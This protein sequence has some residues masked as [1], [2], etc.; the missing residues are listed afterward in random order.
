M[1]FAKDSNVIVDG[2]PVVLADSGVRTANG[3]GSPMAMGERSTLRL[4]LNV[5]AASGGTPTMTASVQHSEDGQSWSN[6]S[7]FTAATGTG[8][9]RKVF[10]GL[11][12]FVRVSWTV[13]G[14]T[15]SFTFAVYGELV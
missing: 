8:T 6:H 12:R 3:S 1:S 13:G 5:T 2:A 10:G 4:T 15:P 9:Q 7:S 11:D 14:T